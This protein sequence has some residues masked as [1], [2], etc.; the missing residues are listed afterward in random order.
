MIEIDKTLIS[1]DVIQE[2]FLCD[3]TACKGACCVHGDAGAPLEE[4]ELSVL[5]DQYINIKSFL[6]EEGIA[7]IEQN[8]KYT[9]DADGDYV[10]PLV[11]GKECAYV[12]FDA[13]GITKC[14]IEKAYEQGVTSFRKPI[15]CH[16]YPIRT[17]KYEKFEAVN[18]HQWDICKAAVLC[19]K[20]EK[21]PVY[22]FLK[23]PLILKY[24]KEW[25]DAL[26]AYA[27]SLE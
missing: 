20:K 17:K 10:T 24:G 3:L 8:G 5:D 9:L 18:Y 4:E 26:S 6:R 22:K 25:Y 1:D 27:D 21:L 15:S 13:E 19:G 12:V 16:L 7:A 14:G 2:Q 23:E 11:N